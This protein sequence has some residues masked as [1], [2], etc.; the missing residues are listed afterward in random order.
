MSS[1]TSR[2]VALALFLLW[3]FHAGLHC[4]HAGEAHG[5]VAGVM[6]HHADDSHDGIDCGACQLSLAPGL[7]GQTVRLSPP[8]LVEDIGGN[9]FDLLCSREFLFASGRGPPVILL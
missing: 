6:D 4:L 7:C 5:Q 1:R 3:N 2:I 9:E 8:N